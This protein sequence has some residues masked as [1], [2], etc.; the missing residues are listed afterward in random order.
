MI[1]II[2]ALAFALFIGS[3][4]AQDKRQELWNNV[5]FH[6]LRGDNQQAITYMDTIIDTGVNL[7]KN[8][9]YRGSLKQQA[10]MHQEAIADFDKT[11]ALNPN[12]IDAFVKR[13]M[14]KLELE[15]FDE[16]IADFDKGIGKHSWQDS[17]A[18]RYRGHAYQSLGKSELALEDYNAA[19]AY[20]P[21]DIELI[22]NTA[23]AYM[24]IGENEKAFSLI[25]KALKIEQNYI[26]KTKKKSVLS[27]A[28]YIN[29]KYT[30][31][32]SLAYQKFHPLDDQNNMN[33]GYLY[34][35]TRKPEDALQNLNKIKGS[36]IDSFDFYY[37]RAMAYY[38]LLD[39]QRAAANFEAAIEKKPA[40][41]LSYVFLAESYKA[42]GDQVKA[43]ESLRKASEL[44]VLGAEEL[45]GDVG[46]K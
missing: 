31:E 8:Y 18:H 34:V 40:S 37:N 20:N 22:S 7:S 21:K 13:G 36:I 1:K 44:G 11:I 30:L 26:E 29:V 27:I 42:F 35:R 41:G 32:L 6:N 25:E 24:A 2:T 16:A 9:L 38:Y 33:I 46:C 15:K 10:G 17:V 19:L 4:S 43:C 45:M 5:N 39:N 28:D 14:A 23:S 12:I 3:V